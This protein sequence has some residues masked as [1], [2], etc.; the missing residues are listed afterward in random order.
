MRRTPLT[1]EQILAWADQW[2][3]ERGR[4]PETKDGD[5]RFADETWVNIDQALRVG[6]R[7]L[8]RG[9]SLARILDKHRGKRNRKRLP[10]YTI[11]QILKWADAHHQRTGRWPRNTDGFIPGTRGETWNAV[12]MA[13]SHGQRGLP[14]G[15]SLACLLAERRGTIN[16]MAQPPLSVDQIRQWIDCFHREHGFFPSSQSGEIPGAKGETWLA[17]DKALRSGRRGLRKS[18]LIKFLQRHYGV[19][20]HRRRPPYRIEQI[21]E[22]IDEHHQRTGEWPNQKSGRIGAAPSETWARVSEA[23]RLGKRGLKGGS[24]LAML[25]SQYRGVRTRVDLP[26]LSDDLILKWARAFKRE[27]GSWPDRN[28]GP[29]PNS[30]GR[31]LVDHP[32]RTPEWTPRA[33]AAVRI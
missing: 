29:I 9:Q 24:S 8:R 13:L 23:L 31:N 19:G 33:A 3:A 10:K 12:E 7:G 26:R 22:W 14:G 32:Q 30:G 21:L 15:T 5:L 6:L 2:K 11:D 4:W 28:S 18:S 16:R 1:V 25:L 20:R 27:H 17:V